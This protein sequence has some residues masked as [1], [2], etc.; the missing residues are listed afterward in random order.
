MNIIVKVEKSGELDS[1]DLERY[2]CTC[3]FKFNGCGCQ[4]MSMLGSSGNGRDKGLCQ[5][6]NRGPKK[7]LHQIFPLLLQIQSEKM[8]YTTSSST[9]LLVGFDLVCT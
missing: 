8:E 6:L 1:W 4:G 3:R 9:S 7:G 5:N 2:L